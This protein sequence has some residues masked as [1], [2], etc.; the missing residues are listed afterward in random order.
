MAR[1]A[2]SVATKLGNA[3]QLKIVITKELDGAMRHREISKMLGRPAPV[4]SLIIQGALA[5]DSTPGAEELEARL[6]DLLEASATAG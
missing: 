3:V 4:P 2:E 6:R 5:F 1:V